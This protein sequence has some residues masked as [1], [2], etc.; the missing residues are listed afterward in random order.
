MHLRVLLVHF[1]VYDSVNQARILFREAPLFE[2]LLLG[3]FVP[4][5]IHRDGLLIEIRFAV[6]TLKFLRPI[7]PL[8]VFHNCFVS[9]FSYDTPSCPSL[10]VYTQVRSSLRKQ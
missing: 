5:F 8:S 1:F 3:F 2:S 10:G 6:G 9:T 7:F 4:R